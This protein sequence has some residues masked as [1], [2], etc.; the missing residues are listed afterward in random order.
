MSFPNRCS[1]ALLKCGTPDWFPFI[2]TLLKKG[3]EQ[4][5]LLITQ[6]ICRCNSFSNVGYATSVFYRVYQLN[7]YFWNSIIK[8]YC[9]YSSVSETITIFNRMKSFEV[10]PD[11]FTF[12]SLIKVCSGVSTIR[13]GRALHG[14]I[15]G[16]NNEFSWTT[17][18]ECSV[19]YMTLEDLAAAVKLFNEMPCRNPASWNAMIGGYLFDKM[20]ERNVVSFTSLIC[21]YAKV[22]D[23]VSSRFFFDQSL[24]RDIVSW[25]VLISGYAQ[26]GEPNEVVKIFLEMHSKNVKPDEFVMVSLMSACSQVGNLEP[27]KWV[28]SYVVQNTMDLCRAHVTAALIDMNAKYLF[29]YCFMIQGP[30]IHGLRAQ[31]VGLFSRMLD[32]GITLDD[33]A[34]TVVLNAC[35][36]ASLVE[37][38]CLYFNS[39]KNDYSIIPSPDHYAC[40]VDLLGRFGKLKAA[41]EFIK[42]MP[43]E[44]HVGAWG[45][46]PWCM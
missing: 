36:H 44:P 9:D 29:S 10:A 42:T 11:E 34:F 16:T 7:I 23:M 3:A 5:N 35:S 12:P 40:M 13:K 2:S 15:T 4:D 17:M 37:D 45:A 26:N 46:L 1:D 41:Y 24:V 18:S 21:G 33:V 32:E 22:G 39:M 30:S 43:V 31:A 8:G 14:S 20:I 25:S 28:D 6:F 27:A 19:W 38:G